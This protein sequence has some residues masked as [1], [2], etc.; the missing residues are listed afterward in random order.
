MVEKILSSFKAGTRDVAEFW[1]QMR[2]NV[3]HIRYFAVRDSAGKYRG[4][5]EVSQDIT[6]IQKITGQKRL[7]DWE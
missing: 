5:L 3:I 6:Q 2:G 1:I 7:L 4:C